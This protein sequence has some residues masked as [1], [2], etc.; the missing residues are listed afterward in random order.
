MVIQW[1]NRFPKVATDQESAR[2]FIS[3]AF[4]ISRFMDGIVI[5]T[6]TSPTY[7]TVTDG[8]M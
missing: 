8:Y 5:D 7:E 1:T 2:G 3:E 4:I 6:I